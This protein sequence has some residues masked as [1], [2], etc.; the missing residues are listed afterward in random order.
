[1]HCYSADEF[2]EELGDTFYWISLP[3][4]PQNGTYTFTVNFTDGTVD[5]ATDTQGPL[6]ALPIIQAWQVTVDGNH[7]TTPTF[8]WPD[9]SP[10]NYYR[11]QIFDQ[12]G[13]TLFRSPRSTDLSVTIPANTIPVG[14]NYQ[15]R[16][17][18]HDSD[19]FDTLNNRSNGEIIN[20]DTIIIPFAGVTNV[21]RPDGIKT[22]LDLGINVDPRVDPSFVARAYVNGPGG[23]YYEFK[24]ED[25][26]PAYGEY[27]QALDGSPA[28]GDYIFTVELTDG[29]TQSVTDTQGPLETLPI[30]RSDE[31][32]IIGDDGVTPTFKWPEVTGRVL[33]YRLIVQDSVGNDIIRTS[34]LGGT[35][36]VTTP[37]ELNPNT[38]Y[39]LRVEI[40]DSNYFETLENRSNGEM[41]TIHNR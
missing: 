40:H 17:E 25:Y 13:N 32:E 22:Q 33:F 18:V 36:Y 14:I 35:A 29:T 16:V 4:P 11:L 34:R 21:N 31:Y 1:M 41:L 23:F 7:T 28:L 15:A 10:G 20:L 39:Q 27:F 38:N 9:V 24:K 8:S 37:G 19:S 6:V 26:L 5:T 12:S 3:G 2:Y 30:I